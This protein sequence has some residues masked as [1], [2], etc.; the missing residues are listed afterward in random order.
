[1]ARGEGSL[2]RKFFMVRISCKWP[3][4]RP[5][6]KSSTS[7][8]PDECT[9]AKSQSRKSQVASRKVLPRRRVEREMLGKTSPSNPAKVKWIPL[10]R[11]QNSQD[12]SADDI[13]QS[14]VMPRRADHGVEQHYRSV[15]PVPVRSAATPSS[16][17]ADHD[18]VIDKNRYGPVQCPRGPEIHSRQRRRWSPQTSFFLRVA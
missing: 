17:R 2:R 14:D 18:P 10:E 6:I 16:N 3:P 7:R 5:I 4:L 1:M 11:A 8:A 15:G 12:S 13:A 9:V